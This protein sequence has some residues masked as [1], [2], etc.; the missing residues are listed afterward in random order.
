MSGAYVLDAIPMGMDRERHACKIEDTAGS[1]TKS[2]GKG[3]P[4]LKVEGATV[5]SSS[6][7]CAFA[8]EPLFVL[9]ILVCAA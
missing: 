2:F 6:A 3:N 1:K 4:S 9:A 5:G 8:P 7:G